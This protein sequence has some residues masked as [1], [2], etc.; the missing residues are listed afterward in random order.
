[1]DHAFLYASGTLTDIGTLGGTH[2]QATSLNDAGQATGWSYT[3]GNQ[4]Q[5]AFLYSNGTMT[6]IGTLG[7]SYSVGLAINAS[8]Q[9]A[10]YSQTLNNN[11]YHAFLYSTGT[12]VDLGTLG[13]SYSQPRALNN[14]GEVT[15]WSDSAN[16]NQQIAFR[17]SGG[18]MQDLNTLV[19][20]CSSRNLSDGV[21][22]NNVGQIAGYGYRSGLSLG[23]VMSPGSPPSILPTTVTVSP[24]TGSYNESVGLFAVVSAS[25]CGVD[26]ASVDLHLPGL[27]AL[28]STTD[29]SGIVSIGASLVGINAGTY[30]DG[31]QA[32]YQATAPMRQAATRL[33]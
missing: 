10:G 31:I 1:M 22:I 27:P 5:R 6:E 3:P 25:A 29:A 32:E 23:F 2:S 30:V 33:T 24:A 15:G 26:G 9:V 18:G 21:S 17:Y 12:L 20:V 8:G 19:G 14:A 16:N 4:S 28:T 7:G 11:S 13:G